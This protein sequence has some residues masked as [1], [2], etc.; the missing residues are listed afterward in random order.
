MAELSNAF[1]YSRAHNNKLLTTTNCLR[2]GSAVAAGYMKTWPRLYTLVV[3]F[4]RKHVQDLLTRN[5]FSVFGSRKK[6]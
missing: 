4:T 6:R 1:L 3:F 5:S 2:G